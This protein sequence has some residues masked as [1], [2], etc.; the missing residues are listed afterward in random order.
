[1][2]KF[3]WF[4]GSFVGAMAV[5]LVAWWL[6]VLQAATPESN[7]T[8]SADTLLLDMQF[9]VANLT[10]ALSGEPVTLTQASLADAVVIILG[11]VGCS[12]DQVEVLKWWNENKLAADSI[13]LGIMTLYADPLM[14]VEVSR[15]ESLLLRRA[16]EVDFPALV[17][18]GEEFNPRS[19]GIQTP[20]TVR[21]KDG[22]IVEILRY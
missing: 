21:V 7:F 18:E 22:R 5:C 14:G 2:K 3:V 20:Q 8:G 19:M 6:I 4:I 13:G 9:P 16:S 10:D 17:Y 1:M 12:R 11:G 15:H